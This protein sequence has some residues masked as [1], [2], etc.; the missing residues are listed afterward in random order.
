MRSSD[1]NRANNNQMPVSAIKKGRAGSLATIKERDEAIRSAD[2][3]NM[4]KAR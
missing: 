2:P 1:L 3:A 4:S